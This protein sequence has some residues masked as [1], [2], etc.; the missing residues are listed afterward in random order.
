MHFMRRSISALALGLGLTLGLLGLG[1]RASAQTPSP[2]CVASALAGGT[3]NAI[4]IPA[5]P[6]TGTSALVLVT[7]A[8]ANT[9]AVTLQQIGQPALPVVKLNNI[10]L[11][12]GDIAG[13]GFVILLQAT[14]QSWVDLN[15]ATFS[16][17]VD[18]TGGAINGTTLG[19]TTPS[20]GVFAGG[21][22]AGTNLYS[23]VYPGGVGTSGISYPSAP[24][25]NA[26]DA[27]VTGIGG[28]PSGTLV[29]NNRYPWG[30]LDTSCAGSFTIGGNWACGSTGYTASNQFPL[31]QIS[32]AVGLTVQALTLPACGPFAGTFDATSFTP[33]TS[34][35]VSTCPRPFQS[36]STVTAQTVLKKGM[37][38]HDDTTP[39]PFW[40]QVTSVGTGS[41]VTVDHWFQDGNTNTGQV[42]TGTHLWLNDVRGWYAGLAYTQGNAICSGSPCALPTGNL[43]SGSAVISGIST[44]AQMQAGD[45]INS[46]HLPTTVIKSVDS[47]SQITVYGPGATGTQNGE[48][49]LVS[50]SVKNQWRLWE[51]DLAGESAGFTIVPVTKITGCNAV[52]GSNQLTGCS[53]IPSS[54]RPWLEVYPSD[55]TKVTPGVEILSIDSGTSLTLNLPAIGTGSVDLTD[56]Q[57][58]V[59]GGTGHDGIG[60]NVTGNTQYSSRGNI[61][62]GFFSHGAFESG[63]IVRP[64][65]T[66]PLPVNG[67]EVDCSVAGCPSS[68][69]F[70][71]RNS[72][73]NTLLA[74]IDPSGNIF[75][76]GVGTFTSLNVA[77]GG[78]VGIPSGYAG[79]IHAG[80]DANFAIGLGSF[81]GFSGTALV[82]INDAGAAVEPLV[83]VGSTITPSGTLNLGSVTGGGASSKTVCVDGSNNVVLKAGAC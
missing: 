82:S 2:Q 81:F 50:A 21:A 51:D 12:A 79:N 35:N 83:L 23:S 80:A 70:V 42:P 59:E 11:A 28:Y 30:D 47:A 40:G 60:L 14:G 66:G 67:F 49:L 17:P 8:G 37:W 10:P 62:W 25:S 41:K 18:I 45:L 15:A 9:G 22:L 56:Y 31:L 3:V 48:N 78:S 44:T 77:F 6:C 72:R 57:N 75:G 69:G 38:L 19:V 71:E 39:A 46:V 20:V 36:T 55:G 68:Y 54:W 29:V 27:I 61:A 7:A 73:T 33:S 58:V 63:F 24:D 13:A 4:T 1:T 76:A 32:D 16:G 65:G 53:A 26:T 74:W 43:V 64:D 52:S 5:L 34:F